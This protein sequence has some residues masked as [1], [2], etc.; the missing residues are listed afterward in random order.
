MQE[1]RQ[2]IGVLKDP[3]NATSKSNAV[4]LTAAWTAAGLGLTSAAISAYWALGGTGLLETI[5]GELERW[6]R[7]RGALVVVML[8]VIVA[9][10]SGVALAAPVLVGVGKARLPRWV[11]GRVTRTLGWIAASTLTVYGGYLT[12]GGLLVMSGLL[13]IGSGEPSTAFAWHAYFW[14]PWFA[15]WGLALGAS[16]WITRPHHRSAV[17]SACDKAQSIL[18]VRTG[19]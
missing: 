14:D 8:W 6:G 16:L 10:K 2:E 12:L 9:I 15:I 3:V 13:E 1:M 5:G 17:R 19:Q 7:E 11:T 18:D 4:A